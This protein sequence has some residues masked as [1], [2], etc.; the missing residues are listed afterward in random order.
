MMGTTSREGALLDK[1]LP[2]IASKP[3]RLEA[4][5]RE[6]DWTVRERIIKVYPHYPSK[7]GAIDVS[8]D[9]TFWQ[10]SVLIAEA[11]ARLAP[12]WS[13]RFDYATLMTRLL[14]REAT[15]GLDLPML[16]GTVGQGALG[17]FYLFSKRTSNMVSDRFRTAF[18]N[19]VRKSDPGWSMYDADSRKTY[20]FDRENREE[21]DPRRD[22]RVA[23]G[24]FIVN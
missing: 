4:L 3:D 22:R 19:F 24:E 5:F 16:F 2:V 1:A 6:T 20:I 12:C 18:M 11:H 23:W 10:P 9:L 13:Y 21:S 17:M 14:F 7:R 15:H 8:G